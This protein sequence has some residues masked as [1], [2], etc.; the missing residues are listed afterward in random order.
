MVPLPASLSC[1]YC[2]CWVSCGSGIVLRPQ[3]SATDPGSGSHPS[4][5]VAPRLLWRWSSFLGRCHCCL[6]V[7]RGSVCMCKCI[8]VCLHGI[9]LLM[10]VCVC[11]CACVQAYICVCVCV[12]VRVC[13]CASM[14]MC[15]MHVVCV[16]VS[17]C[18]HVCVHACV[19]VCMLCKTA[20]NIHYI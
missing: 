10:C 2:G 1:T 15:V 13:A 9:S 11:V 5:C 20:T 18:M 4:Q 12:H 14:H 6:A 17:A 19:S 16:C 7:F 3:P 8:H